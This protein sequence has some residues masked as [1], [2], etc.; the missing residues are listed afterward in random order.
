MIAVS[1]TPK[2]TVVAPITWRC[3]ARVRSR[4]SR[5]ATDHAVNQPVSANVAGL[6]SDTGPVTG[7]PVTV[8]ATMWNSIVTSSAPPTT[9][10]TRGQPERTTSGVVMPH[11]PG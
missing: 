8:S 4:G 9:H 10:S 1:P 2:S 5:T 6:R 3:H 11:P 7:P